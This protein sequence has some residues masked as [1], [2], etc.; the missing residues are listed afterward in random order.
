VELPLEVLLEPELV[1]LFSEVVLE[2]EVEPELVD[3]V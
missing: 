1:E 2:L 3:L